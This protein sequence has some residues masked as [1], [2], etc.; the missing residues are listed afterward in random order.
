MPKTFFIIFLVLAVIGIGGGGFYYFEIYQPRE[1]AASAL[2]LYQKL[3][4][5]GLQPD[6][7]SLAGA[8]DYESALQVLDGRIKMLESVQ[9]DLVTIKT[10]KQLENYQKEFSEYIDFTLAQHKQAVRFGVF[11]KNANTV[12]TAMTALQHQ[13]S[14]PIDE[15]NAT[16]GDFQR[17]LGERFSKIQDSAEMLFRDEITESTKPSF[18]GLKS[19][20]KDASP[21]LDLFFKKLNALNP[22]LSVNRIGN[23]FTPLEAQKFQGYTKKLEEFSKEIEDLAKQYSAYDL[24]IFRYFPDVSP[25]EANERTLKFYQVIQKLK[26]QYAE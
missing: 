5:A 26:E 20:W 15:K 14:S 9:K 11:I 18:F 17:V 13:D 24:L 19:L 4:S 7:S 12:R 2:S 3:E 8:A 21:G 10:P 25:A 6:T 16:V 23:M 22:H 1:Y